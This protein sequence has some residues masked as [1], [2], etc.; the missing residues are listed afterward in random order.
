MDELQQLS[1]GDAQLTAV[2]Y[3][4]KVEIFQYGVVERKPSPDSQS[5]CKDVMS[6][7]FRGL[8]FRQL[9]LIRV[10]GERVLLGSL[11]AFC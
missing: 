2:K 11:P 5:G 3:I 4:V 8:A 9:R 1:L 7:V 10:V 6:N